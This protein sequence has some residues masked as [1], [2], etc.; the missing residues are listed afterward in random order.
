MFLIFCGH[1]F[2]NEEVAGL[3]VHGIKTNY[4]LAAET[5]DRPSD[6]DFRACALTQI[7][8]YIWR[9]PRARWFRHELQ[10]GASLA[11][12]SM[13]RNGDWPSCTEIAC[14]KVSSNTGSPV[15]LLKS[16]RTTVSWSVSF[17]TRCERQ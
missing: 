11:S 3:A 15:V 1:L 13:F 16:A 6:I 17:G 5:S 7:T 12:E 10:G 8:R 9:H 2:L 4:I 14:F